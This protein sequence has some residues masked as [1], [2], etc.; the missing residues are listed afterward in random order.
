MGTMTDDLELERQRL[1]LERTKK[2]QIVIDD[3]S[4]HYHAI[5]STLE[6][7]IPHLDWENGFLY[8]IEDNGD[9][10]TDLYIRFGQLFNVFLY[11][12]QRGH[13]IQEDAIVVLEP[14]SW[15]CD[16]RNFP[17]GFEKVV[18]KHI[19]PANITAAF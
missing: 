19:H 2:F 1:E 18:A 11:R 6:S 5:L 16:G 13:L 4:H 8:L 15:G 3:A 7:F 9:V 14:K 12:V 10:S 17:P